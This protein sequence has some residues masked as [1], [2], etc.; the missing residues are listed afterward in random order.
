MILSKFINIKRPV[1]I[2]FG[3]SSFN[4]KVKAGIRVG[5]EYGEYSLKI[6]EV[7]KIKMTPWN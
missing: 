5:R 7:K 3:K 4:L 1:V 6:N 2:L